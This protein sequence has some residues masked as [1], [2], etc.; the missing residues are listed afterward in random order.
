MDLSSCCR[1]VLKQKF[2][3]PRDEP[4]KPKH[5]DGSNGS[6]APAVFTLVKTP[7]PPTPT[8]DLSRPEHSEGIFNNTLGEVDFFDRD[9]VRQHKEHRKKYEMGRKCDCSGAKM[10]SAYGSKKNSLDETRPRTS[11]V[12]GNKVKSPKLSSP[13]VVSAEEERRRS[14]STSNLSE[15][16]HISDQCSAAKDN[17][18]IMGFHLHGRR[19]HCDK[20][21]EKLFCPKHESGHRL[22][23]GRGR[24]KSQEPLQPAVVKTTTP[25]PIEMKKMHLQHQPLHS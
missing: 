17:E 21:E 10:S 7:T 8:H 25:P 5:I 13:A 3:D 4:K 15:L 1:R 20:T 14:K 16:V 11:S 12:N 22:Y 18:P 19:R 2:S 9:V 24:A 6:A 23:Y